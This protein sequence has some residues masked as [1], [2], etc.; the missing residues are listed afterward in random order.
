MGVPE[1][2]KHVMSVIR[3][4]KWV[5][6]GIMLDDKGRERNGPAQITRPDQPFP[7]REGIC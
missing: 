1:D 7:Q 2:V 4:S 5:D 3:Q 6:D